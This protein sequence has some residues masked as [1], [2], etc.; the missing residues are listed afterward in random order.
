M[1]FSARLITGWLAGL[2]SALILLAAPR[3][4][5]QVLVT[6]ELNKKVFVAYEPILAT[7]TVSNRAG[8]DII[9]GDHHG[10][11]WLSFQVS[12]IG[13]DPILPYRGAP[14]F[15]PKVLAAGKSIR[16]A[17]PL[18][19][20]FPLGGQDNYSIRAAVYFNET[21]QHFG[22]NVAAIRVS[23]GQ[24]FWEDQVGIPRS[25]GRSDYRRFTLLTFQEEDRMSVFVRVRDQNSQRV[26]ATYSLGRLVPHR[27]PQ[28][29]LDGQNRL[30]VLFLTGPRFFRHCVIDAD[31]EKVS[32]DVFE[33]KDGSLPTLMLANTG[34]V[35]V[36]G[37]LKFDPN[38]P[39]APPRDIVHRFTDRPPGVPPE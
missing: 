35:R 16:E 26:L 13:G 17:I 5:A 11:S 2:V 12:S 18:G 38:V 20:Y 24:R 33:G 1:T 10:Q 28:A 29:T 8:R 32:E 15:E 21:G 37:G 4:P 31:G 14:R 19:S 30:H 7:V 23:E 34:G 3:A 9:L 27:D 36:E 6:L 25:N 39:A 22:S